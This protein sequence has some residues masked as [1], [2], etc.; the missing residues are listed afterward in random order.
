MV[1][2]IA[3]PNQIPCEGSHNCTCGA[4]D[5]TFSDSLFAPEETKEDPLCACMHRSNSEGRFT[6]TCREKSRTS[7]YVDPWDSSDNSGN[8]LINALSDNDLVRLS[9]LRLHSKQRSADEREKISNVRRGHHSSME[10]LESR[11]RSEP[12]TEDT[13]C[14]YDMSTSSESEVTEYRSHLEKVEQNLILK[15]QVRNIIKS[16][17]ND[18]DNTGSDENSN[19][20][21][22]TDKASTPTVSGSGRSSSAR[23]LSCSEASDTEVFADRSESDDSSGYYDCGE[24]KTDTSKN[25]ECYTSTSGS[26]GEIKSRIKDSASE[27]SDLQELI[28][29]PTRISKSKNKRGIVKHRPRKCHSLR[30]ENIIKSKIAEDTEMYLL[31]TNRRHSECSDVRVYKKPVLPFQN[32]PIYHDPYRAKTGGSSNRLLTDLIRMN[33]DK[34]H[35]VI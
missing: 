32:T 25:S 8:S 16:L 29:L 14:E 9:L 11:N 5:R 15:E 26:S 18:S 21:D 19:T 10:S 33:Y 28:L 22:G 1:V 24:D 30:S 2:P 27:N 35:M 17:S 6:C 31:P 12:E 3:E 34:Q 20:V 4:S 23:T 13:G 7:D